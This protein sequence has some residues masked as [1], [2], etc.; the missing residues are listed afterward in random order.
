MTISRPRLAGLLIAGF[1]AV[2]LVAVAPAQSAAADHGD[3][4]YV[5]VGDSFSPLGLEPLQPP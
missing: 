2:A 1:A 5:A 4:Q 3:K